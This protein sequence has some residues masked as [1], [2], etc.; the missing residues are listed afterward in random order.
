MGLCKAQGV[1]GF[2][3]AGLI[4][5]TIAHTGGSLHSEFGKN[6]G[7]RK[8]SDWFYLNVTHLAGNVYKSLL[9]I[10]NSY[11]ESAAEVQSWIPVIPNKIAEV[12]IEFSDP[13]K[14]LDVNSYPQ[15][16][17]TLEHLLVTRRLVRKPSHYTGS[18]M[19]ESDSEEG[20]Y[21]KRKRCNLSF[22]TQEPRYI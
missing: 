14:M 6:A 15:H 21:C 20:Q 1:V 11:S 3:T 12:L 16:F 10:S 22:Y 17:H 2:V 5:W 13:L 7:V 9:Y 18:D 4:E 19:D 8:S